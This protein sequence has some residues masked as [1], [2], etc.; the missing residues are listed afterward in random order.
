VPYTRRP[1]AARRCAASGRSRR[2]RSSRTRPTRARPKL[3]RDLRGPGPAVDPRAG[4]PAGN[5]VQI[6]RP[7]SPKDPAARIDRLLSQNGALHPP[8]PLGAGGPLRSHRHTQLCHQVARLRGKCVPRATAGDEQSSEDNREVPA[9]HTPVVEEQA[10]PRG[11]T[12]RHRPSAP[13]GALGAAPD[14]LLRSLARLWRARP[15][16][17]G[18]ARRDHRE[19][20]K[21][22]RHF[23]FVGRAGERPRAASS[24][25]S[26]GRQEQTPRRAPSRR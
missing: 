15:R 19:R 13:G 20:W 8:D 16:T 9:A 14:A 21:R 1:L 18:I 11:H 25:L 2:R 22:G 10:A 5:G 23:R 3:P 4:S 12:A 17:F 24:S 6:T 7:E 26:K